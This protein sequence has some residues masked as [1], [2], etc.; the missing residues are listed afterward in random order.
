MSESENGK[1]MTK[2]EK[3]GLKRCPS[4]KSWD[5]YPKQLEDGSLG[6]WCPHC[7]EFLQKKKLKGDDSKNSEP[8][9]YIKW[10]KNAESFGEKVGITIVII[11]ILLVSFFLKYC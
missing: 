2:E 4:C 9:L 6:Y 10:Y 7:L 11:F 8:L 1:L 5:V 3:A